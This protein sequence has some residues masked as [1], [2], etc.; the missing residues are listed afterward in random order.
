MPNY[1][2]INIS[3]HFLCASP[4]ALSA[5]DRNGNTFFCMYCRLGLAAWACV[6]Q[7]RRVCD[8]LFCTGTSTGQASFCMR[9]VLQRAN[10]DGE[11]ASSRRKLTEKFVKYAFK[12]ATEAVYSL[13][14]YYN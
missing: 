4:T 6:V 10:F 7:Q 8:A 14:K 3:S 13:F 11:N 1:G 5:K 12:N 2:I 9:N